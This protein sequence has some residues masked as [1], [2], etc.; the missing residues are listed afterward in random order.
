MEEQTTA[1]GN[2]DTGSDSG[3]KKVVKAQGSAPLTQPLD[4]LTSE[5]SNV[6]VSA[7][8]IFGLAKTKGLKFED[9]E[10]PELGEGVKIRVRELNGFEREQFDR[11]IA[12]VTASRPGNTKGRKKRGNGADGGTTVEY[13][14]EKIR[15]ELCFMCCIDPQGY[16]L[17]NTQED[18]LRLGNLSAQIL[19]RM[20]KRIMILSDM[21]K[22][23]E[24]EDEDENEDEDEDEKGFDPVEKAR[25][26]F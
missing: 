18:K 14:A 2:K 12:T 5:F 20:F 6:Q 1:V 23:D 21:A 22:E 11:Q 17:F 7:D 9:V 10:I 19:E 16:K 15:L 4:K 3:G 13:H 26:E 8:A 25:G 24:D